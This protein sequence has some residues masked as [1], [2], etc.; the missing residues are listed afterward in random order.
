LTS[1]LAGIIANLKGA[2]LRPPVAT[3][4]RCSAKLHTN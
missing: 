2:W 3:G 1:I 4:Y